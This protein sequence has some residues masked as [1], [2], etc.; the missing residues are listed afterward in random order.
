ME[1]QITVWIG[2]VL[3][4]ASLNCSEAQVIPTYF[5]VGG[6]LDLRPTVTETITDILWKYNENLLAEWVKDEA[7]LLYFD[8]YQGRTTL[9]T[10]TGQ[11]VIN[12]MDKDDVGMY[13][14]ERNN[15]VHGQSYDVR[16]I[17]RVPKPIV[18]DHGL[19]R[20]VKNMSEELIEGSRRVDEHMMKQSF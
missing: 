4:L 9:N 3:L 10:A 8:K 20:W 12:N 11:L 15:R 7:E 18:S 13:T 16:W 17:T 6:T 14:V 19:C 5:E 2:A 1:K